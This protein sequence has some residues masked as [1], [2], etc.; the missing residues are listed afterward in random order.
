MAGK[1][2]GRAKRNLKSRT[3]K[4]SEELQTAPHT[5][6]FHRGTRCLNVRSLISD[7][8]LM[9]EPFTASK[10]HITRRNILKDITSIAGLLHVT[11]L[12]ILSRSAMHMC[13]RV[14]SLPAGPTIKFRITQFINVQDIRKSTQKPVTDQSLFNAAPMLILSKSPELAKTKSAKESKLVSTVF[15]RSFPS[16]NVDTVKI[17]QVRRCVLLYQE[18][19]HL[20]QLRHYAIKCKLSNKVNSAVRRLVNNRLPPDLSTCSDIS[21]YVYKPCMSESEDD[22]NVDLP[23]DINRLQKE[24]SQSAIRLKEIGPRL[25]LELIR[26]EDDVCQ[27]N[28]LWPPGSSVTAESGQNNS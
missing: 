21:D 18:S 20:Y 23:Q 27:G 5:F 3:Q 6:V 9:L 15:Q 10:L 19:P 12:W 14:A 24:G 1:R 7:L 2:K 25:N 4:E 28:R 11:H 16:F 13:L 26:I 22:E 8:R 17:N